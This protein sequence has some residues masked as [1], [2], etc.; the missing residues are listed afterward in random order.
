M[1]GKINLNK[2]VSEKTGSAI[3]NNGNAG[4]VKNVQVEVIKKKPEDDPQSPDFKVFFIDSAGGKINLGV[5]YPTERTSDK[6][7][8]IRTDQ[9]LSILFAL[10]PEVKNSELPEFDTHKQVFDYLLK[11]IAVNSKNVPINVFVAYGTQKSPSVH[12]AFRAFEIAESADTPDNSTRLVAQVNKGL[13]NDIM[14]RPSP[15]NFSKPESDGFESPVSVSS[16]STDEWPN[17]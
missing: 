5:Y 3:F 6:E 14:E 8:A 15:T 4:R 10:L 13:Y 16:T 1:S 17:E 12:L 11:Q 7:L 2:I 9:L